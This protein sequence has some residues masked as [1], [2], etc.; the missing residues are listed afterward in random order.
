MSPPNLHDPSIL[1]DPYPVY[2][3]AFASSAVCPSV[4][5]SHRTWFVG[6]HAEV[7]SLL[8]D[9]RLS[10]NRSTFLAHRLPPPVLE[11]ATPLLRS[12]SHWILFKDPP[13]HTPWRRTINAAL[14][15]RLVVG[16]LP[17]IEQLVEH[18]LDAAA[19]RGRMEV[20]TDLAYPLPAT[21]VAQ[22]L[23]ADPA[24]SERL[25]RWSQDI[26]RLLGG[27]KAPTDFLHA[28][29]SVTA[30]TEYFR[31]VLTRHR[32]EPRDDLLA[33]LL[34]ATASED[35]ETGGDEALLSN[36]VGLM[37]AGHETTT[38]LIGNAVGILLDRPALVQRLRADP[39]GWDRVIEEVLRFESP[40]QRVSRVSTTPL[41]VD[42]S[43][44]PAGHRVVMVLAAANRDPRVFAQPDIFDPDRHPNPH[45]GFGYGIH[46]CSGAA[47]ARIEARA[48][49]GALVERFED[50]Q[51]LGP[52]EWMPN[53][54]LRSIRELPISVSPRC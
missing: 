2:R 25:R 26:A 4:D 15:R 47:L 14:S 40:V 27:S 42:G 18:L 11:A 32:A 3:Q 43:R 33:A 29:Q 37:F 19:E 10:S 24:D 48:A 23:G 22:M 41:E 44:I 39:S 9:P 13:E 45:L 21:V 50:L 12:L 31:E 49:L 52:V 6:R 34:S 17:A 7:Q 38:N 35:G 5:P 20:V 36:C 30:M 16:M 8:R 54:G 46:L 51:R 1:Q 53:F 28:H